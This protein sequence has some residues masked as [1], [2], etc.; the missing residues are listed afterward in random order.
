MKKRILSLFLALVMLFSCLSLN[1]FAAETDSPETQET[2]TPMTAEELKALC[3]ANGIGVSKGYDLTMDD[4]AALESSMLELVTNSDV[5]SDGK[6]A[7]G[8]GSLKH[9]TI[10]SK[11]FIDVGGDSGTTFG[12]GDIK[13]YYKEDIELVEEG[14][15]S[16]YR[17]ANKLY[18]DADGTKAC[19]FSYTEDANG[20]KTFN[21]D[22][23]QSCVNGVNK[24]VFAS[25]DSATLKASEEAFSPEV[26]SKITRAGTSTVYTNLIIPVGEGKPSIWNGY[27]TDSYIQASLSAMNSNS[28]YFVKDASYLGAPYAITFDVRHRDGVATGDFLSNL[29]GYICKEYMVDKNTSAYVTATLPVK[30]NADGTVVAAGDETD[31]KLTPEQWY[32]LTVYHTP[33]GLDGIKGT[34]DDN[35]FHVLVDGELVATKKVTFTLKNVSNN[36]F[37]VT[38]SDKTYDLNIYTDFVLGYIRFGQNIKASIDI[39]DFRLYRGNLLEHAHKWEYSHK[40]DVENCQNVLVA[41][42][43]LCGKT[44][45]KDVSMLD[46][47]TLYGFSA[48][49]IAKI[50]E[51]NTA[52]LPFNSAIT[53]VT[54]A[55]NVLNFAGLTG[56]TR[57]TKTSGEHIKTVEKTDS[58]GDWYIKW[59]TPEGATEY[60]NLTW[61][62]S[63]KQ[64]KT[65]DKYDEVNAAGFVGASYA[66]TFDIMQHT[67]V[68]TGKVFDNYNVT[69]A[70]GSGFDAAFAGKANVYY[71]FSIDEEG[72]LWI[73]NPEISSS[74][75]QKTDYKFELGDWHQL[76]IYHTPRGLDGNRE[77]TEDNNTYHVFVDGQHI[78]TYLAMK[79]P[80]VAET[81][82]NDG[83]YF[84]TAYDFT[85]WKIQIGAANQQV[86][87]I[88]IDDFRLYY[89]N[90]LECAHT[91]ADGTESIVDG[92]CQWCHQKIA[93]PTEYNCDVCARKI[94]ESGYALN[95]G[96]AVVSRNISLGEEINMNVYLD[97]TD[98]LKNTAGAE[99]VVTVGG[100]E[101]VRL[102]MAE[103]TKSEDGKYKITALL[104]S[105]DM[106]KDVTV[107]VA[108]AEQLG[109]Y[110]TSVAEYL[111]ALIAD[112]NQTAEAVALAKSTLNYGAAAQIYFAEKNPDATL[113]EKLANAKLDDSDKTVTALTTEQLKPFAFKQENA[114]EA[115][116]FTGASLLMSSKTHMKLYFTAP[117]GTAVTVNGKTAGATQED[118][119]Y[120]V[121]I[122]AAN[123]VAA[124]NDEITVA[125]SDGTTTVT[126]TVNV[127]TAVAA[128]LTNGVSG[129]KL[130][131]LLNAYGQYCIAASTYVG[132]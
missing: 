132:N 82:L 62:D 40:H 78:A 74:N 48:D 15:N 118:D 44:E 72:Y 131:D 20:T 110:T 61:S 30:I 91:N 112:K 117:E 41:E 73:M 28:D 47:S 68:N 115:L 3:Q 104:R 27:V 4:I 2:T 80:K 130:V 97:L 35:T 60:D 53:E 5:D 107:S 100:K 26:L 66:I 89:G 69:S 59:E 95:S 12:E 8:L 83:T 90:F 76:T 88:A 10:G 33:R 123:P 119:E 70:G 128:G 34:D 56:V 125:I 109:T 101:S 108:G 114:S 57:T 46:K 75:L 54:S 49:A 52:K 7:L 81:P 71:N 51:N 98:A 79:T 43:G 84:N 16:F 77:K 58:A 55:K 106:T 23:L 120:Y 50:F 18:W 25:Y 63:N 13:I 36:D 1:I 126:T 102:P 9:G 94:T 14:E 85:P 24:L 64:F 65:L 129:E 37:Q 86:N 113:L 45:T 32:Q 105:I 19:D 87:G 116:R 38:N 93:V 122:S 11:L 22:V 17:W 42:C 92:V 99:I 121:F 127:F 31:F 103:L 96:V 111:E 67:A 29:R 21:D 124:M 6:Q 39:D